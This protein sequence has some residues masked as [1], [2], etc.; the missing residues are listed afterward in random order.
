MATPLDRVTVPITVEPSRKLTVPEAVDGETV[1]VKVTDAPEADGF[2][3]DVRVVVVT[4][5]FTV[6]VPNGSGCAPAAQIA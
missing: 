4:A 2:S 3:D 5:G 1:A 6:C